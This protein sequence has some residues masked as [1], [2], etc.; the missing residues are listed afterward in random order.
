MNRGLMERTVV[1][2]LALSNLPAK[3]VEDWANLV[4]DTRGSLTLGTDHASSWLS[5]HFWCVLPSIPGA[6]KENPAVDIWATLQY[7]RDKIRKWEIGEEEWP[8]CSPI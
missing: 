7:E 6:L 2:T 5:K 3:E 1:P 8:N 4:L